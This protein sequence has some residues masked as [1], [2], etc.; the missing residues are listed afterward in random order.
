MPVNKA[1]YGA[2]NMEE[3]ARVMSNRIKDN[4]GTMA[5]VAIDLIAQA[6]AE[7]RLDPLGATQT[8]NRL[9]FL[10]LR[11]CPLLNPEKPECHSLQ[12]VTG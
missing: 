12:A 5:M 4:P 7:M 2:F 10:I 11:C 6:Q 8:L 3:Q 9:Q 1:M